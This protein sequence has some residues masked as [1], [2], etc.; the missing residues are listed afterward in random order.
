MTTTNRPEI[1][2]ADPAI[3]QWTLVRGDTSPLLVQFY[4]T[5]E[6]TSYDTDGWQFAATTYDFKG[7]VLD[8]LEVVAGE[9]YVSIV[10]PASVTQYWGT[11]YKQVVAELAFDLQVTIDNNI[12]W[13]P[14]IGTIKVLGD[15]TG[16]SL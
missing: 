2:G 14:V 4:E 3:V 5:D 16:G 15:V 10:A 12:V 9:G 7:D 11:G 1:I 13:T 6:A 8:E